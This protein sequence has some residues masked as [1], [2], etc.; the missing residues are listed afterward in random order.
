ME[1][2]GIERAKAL[3]KAD[4]AN[5]QPHCGSNANQSVYVAMLEPGDTVMGM[6]LGSRRAP[7][8]W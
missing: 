1:T 6:R 8:T 4:H 5:I 7:N 2:L 3:F